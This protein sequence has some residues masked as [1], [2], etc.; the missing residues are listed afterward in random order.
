MSLQ[1]DDYLDNHLTN[2]KKGLEWIREFLPE[3]LMVR[4]FESYD[5]DYLISLSHDRS[6]FDIF[7][8]EAYDDYFYGGNRSHDVVQTFNKAWLC[9]IH[10]N[11]HHWQYW[12]LIQDDP[13]SPMICLDMD[14]PYILE[15]ICD[16]WSFGWRSG[17]L[18][19]LFDW[20]EERKHHIMLS[21]KSRIIVEDILNRIK[22]K[23][24]ELT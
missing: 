14:Y 13:T 9:H 18:Y 3:L 12:V 23:L 19:E 11:P 1:Y 21:P 4:G 16:W 7:E 24:W 6:K 5:F 8:Y 10:K 2:V 15:M 17:N 20:Y 22:E